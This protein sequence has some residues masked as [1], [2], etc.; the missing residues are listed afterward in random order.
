MGMWTEIVLFVCILMWSIHA[1][2]NV[3]YNNNNNNDRLTAFDPGSFVTIEC[4]LIVV[5]CD[6]VFHTLV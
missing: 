3:Y 2:L 6:N 4:V 5:I 1:V